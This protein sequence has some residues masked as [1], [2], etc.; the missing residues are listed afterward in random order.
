MTSNEV[1]N[2]SKEAKQKKR[3]GDFKRNIEGYML[4]TMLPGWIGFYALKLHSL[5]AV[6]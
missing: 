3:G 6:R 5:I 1:N 4:I 2:G